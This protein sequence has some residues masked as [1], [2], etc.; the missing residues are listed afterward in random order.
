MPY[1][2]FFGFW[3]LCVRS[4]GREMKKKKPS[5]RFITFMYVQSE[6]ARERELKKKKMM[7]EE[8]FTLEKAMKKYFNMYLASVLVAVKFYWS[9]VDF[10]IP[11][12]CPSAIQLS[13]WYNSNKKCLPLIWCPAL[14]TSSF[15]FYVIGFFGR[16]MY[17]V[18]VWNIEHPGLFT[19][20]VTI[21]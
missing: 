8:L 14:F 7:E 20:A 4:V 6:Q 18:F 9:T 12:L 5:L 3:F 19:S 21:N 10:S 11:Y 15:L 17:F 13:G 16:F 1:I 2:F